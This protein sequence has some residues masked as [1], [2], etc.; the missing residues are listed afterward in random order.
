MRNL[1][2]RSLEILCLMLIN[3]KYFSQS[4]IWKCR[5]NCHSVK[6]LIMSLSLFLLHLFTVILYY[7]HYL[8]HSLLNLNLILS[9]TPPRS[10]SFCCSSSLWGKLCKHI[11]IILS[12]YLSLSL[13]KSLSILFFVPHCLCVS[14]V[15]P[16]R[17]YSARGWQ[18]P[19]CCMLI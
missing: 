6:S 5:I 17:H 7:H 16:F 15:I 1:I 19:V 12:L 10:M 13:C 11:E 9:H 3:R 4:V 2:A 8:H 14:Q 18:R